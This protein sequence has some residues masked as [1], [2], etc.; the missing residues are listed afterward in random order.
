[1]DYYTD[2]YGLVGGEE[3]E[4]EEEALERDIWGL[5]LTGDGLVAAAGA[6][7]A[8]GVRARRRRAGGS[9]RGKRSSSDANAG[10]GKI[11]RTNFMI[12]TKDRKEDGVTQVDICTYNIYIRINLYKFM[13]VVSD[14]IALQ[15]NHIAAE[16]NCI[17]PSNCIAM[18]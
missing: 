13:F 4:E 9:R 1:M 11:I 17:L 5:N 14:S 18:N 16:F 2:Y 15:F 10:G 12:C 7:E 8:G 3:Q 6:S